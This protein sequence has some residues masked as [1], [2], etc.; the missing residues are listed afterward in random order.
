MSG[1]TKDQWPLFAKGVFRIC[2]PGTGWAQLIETCAFLTCD[3]GS[4]PK[5]SP[6]WE[7]IHSGLLTD[8]QYQQYEHEIWE[9]E[10]GLLWTPFH[11]EEDLKQ[12]GFV[13]IQIKR[14]QLKT[15]AEGTNPILF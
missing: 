6:I 5:D 4:V 2:K 1:I 8:T 15:W 9:V 11:V 13:D 14:V 10:K 7:V 12:A 3:D